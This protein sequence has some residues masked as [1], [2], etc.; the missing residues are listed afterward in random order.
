MGLE[1][2]E[3][4]T[5][6]AAPFAKS[7]AIDPAL[8]LAIQ[9]ATHD[10]AVLAGN[11]A[12]DIVSKESAKLMAA[13]EKRLIGIE[14]PRAKIAAFNINGLT[15]KLPTAVSEQTALIIAETVANLK[16][17]NAVM[18]VGPSGCGKTEIAKLVAKV[19]GLE[20]HAISWTE[21]MSEGPALF[22]R[23]DKDGT[24][25]A[26]F[27][28][29]F[30][31]GHLFLHDEFPKANANAASKTNMCLANGHFYN[32]VLLENIE[33]HENF[34]C[35]AT[36][37]SPRGGSEVYTA[38]NGLSADVL[39]RFTLIEVDY[40]PEYEKAVCPVPA[41]YKALTQA[42][43][44]LRELQSPEVLTT[45]TFKKAYEAYCDGVQ[46]PARFI[47]STTMLWPEGLAAQ[48]GLD[49][50]W[51]SLN[52]ATEAPKQAASE[53][54]ATV[55]E[56]LPEDEIKPGD[57]PEVVARKNKIDELKK[58]LAGMKS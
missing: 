27:S 25:E 6:N 37:N 56:D 54:K 28:K 12:F 40:D 5:E 8:L 20:F 48:C 9:E 11:R 34:A 36:A 10:A 55:I 24:K 18:F 43:A 31:N 46:S 39:D 53:P 33:R 21:G 3:F 57:L 26:A 50:P 52:T 7:A 42:R 17:K 35:I 47:R 32:E 58:R 13:V 41:I 14:A 1:L 16:R 2:K 30:R 45:R 51:D 29:A 23:Q 38:D 44:K 15:T 49:K 19:M 4:E 22:A